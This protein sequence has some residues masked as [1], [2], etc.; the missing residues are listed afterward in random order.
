MNK[1]G[2]V[3]WNVLIECI[4]CLLPSMYRY[5]LLVLVKDQDIVV[6]NVSKRPRD[7]LTSL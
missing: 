5:C 7:L 1:D 2:A 3:F 6:F 4:F